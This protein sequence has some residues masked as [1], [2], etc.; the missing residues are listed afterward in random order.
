MFVSHDP[1]CRNEQP[2]EIG[3]QMST[4]TCIYSSAK[5][6]EQT[7]P[8]FKLITHTQMHSSDAIRVEIQFGFGVLRKY[9]NVNIEYACTFTLTHT[10]QTQNTYWHIAMVVDVPNEAYGHVFVVASNVHLQLIFIELC[11]CSCTHVK[12]CRLMSV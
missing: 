12:H 1:I 11:I 9:K 3:K 5:L 4:L 10:S 6:L 8:N 7:K 2:N